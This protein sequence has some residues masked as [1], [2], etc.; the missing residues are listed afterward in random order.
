MADTLSPIAYCISYLQRE[1]ED[2]RSALEMAAEN[3]AE[4]AKVRVRV[5]QLEHIRNMLVK[6]A[7]GA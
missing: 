4:S 2:Q 3:I 6:Y 7:G 5:K 1:L